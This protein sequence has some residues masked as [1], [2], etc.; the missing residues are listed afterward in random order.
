MSSQKENKYKIKLIFN[1]EVAFWSKT[2]NDK[3]Y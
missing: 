2:D 3:D 1:N